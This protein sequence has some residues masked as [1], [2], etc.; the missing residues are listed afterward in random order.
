MIIHIL[1]KTLE[2]ENRQDVLDAMFKE[3]SKI[4]NSTDL[5]FSHLII[6]GLEVYDDFYDYF[7]DN[8]KN[9]EVVKVVT[10]TVKETYEE[11]LLSTIDYLERA[12]PEI[13]ILSNEFYKTPSR[14]SW[15]KLGDLLEGIKWIMD[16]FIVIDSNSVLKDVVNS[17]EDWNMYAKD[18]Y[19]LNELLKELEEILE[20]SDFVSTADI[21][22][23]EIIPLFENM[24]KK[25]EKLIAEEVE[26]DDFN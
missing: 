10:K 4:V 1:D 6:D 26:I 2:Y 19:G 9:I 21:L 15:E 23:Y 25:L 18:I 13:G 17:Y 8:I 24:K 3:I 20:N 12:I 22:S 16:T 7:L 14:E 5:V 11:I